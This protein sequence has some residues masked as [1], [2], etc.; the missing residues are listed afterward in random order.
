[1]VRDLEYHN[2]LH[3]TDDGKVKF[4]F[5]GSVGH[6]TRHFCIKYAIPCHLL[7]HLLYLFPNCSTPQK[8]NEMLLELD[9]CI[10]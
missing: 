5:P 3:Y 9:P 7:L 8:K 6:K 1:M 2:L 10:G 4:H